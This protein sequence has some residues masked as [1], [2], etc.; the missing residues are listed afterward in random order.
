MENVYIYSSGIFV[1]NW[2]F[3]F[4][5]IIGMLIFIFITIDVLLGSGKTLDEV[6]VYIFLCIT[7]AI[8]SL[9]ATLLMV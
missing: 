8:I 5:N 1:L 7:M 9:I 2:F 4:F 6:K 3:M